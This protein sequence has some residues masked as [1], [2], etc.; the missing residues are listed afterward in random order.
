MQ[1]RHPRAKSA[2]E[3]AGH[4]WSE[5]D[6]RDEHQRRVF[7]GERAFDAAHVNFRLAAA[8]YAMNEDYTEQ[9]GSNLLL[10]PGKSD[11]LLFTEIKRQVRFYWCNGCAGGCGASDKGVLG[12]CYRTFDANEALA[13]EPCQQTCRRAQRFPPDS[14]PFANALEKGSFFRKPSKHGFSSRQ[15]GGAALGQDDTCTLPMRALQRQHRREDF[16][17]RDKIVMRDPTA[18]PQEFLHENR[19][20]IQNNLDGFDL[21][22]PQLRGSA[23]R[24]EERRVGK[25]C[26][27]R[28]S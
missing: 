12:N 20:I 28:W 27:S 19:G 14:A 18:Q 23:H 11:G 10:N 2:G 26:R 17:L 1:N 3:Q 9:S 16:T 6:L 24:S 21:F 15:L 22:R 5:V 7:A 25:E 8:C 13:L 4:G